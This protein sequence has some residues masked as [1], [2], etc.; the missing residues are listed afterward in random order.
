MLDAFEKILDIK[1]ENP[2]LFSVSL[3]KAKAEARKKAKKEYG[4]AVPTFGMYFV[5]KGMKSAKEELKV[6]EN[7][8]AY[9]EAQKPKVAELQD[10]RKKKDEVFAKMRLETLDGFLDTKEV[11]KEVKAMAH[12]KLQDLM[13]AGVKDAK[14]GRT[15]GMENVLT[16]ISQ[17]EKAEGELQGTDYFEGG[18]EAS[19]TEQDKDLGYK[20]SA[21]RIRASVQISI[22]RSVAKQI[23]VEIDKIS[24]NKPDALAEA[25]KKLLERTATK[26]VG[27]MPKEEIGA[28][29]GTVIADRKYVYRNDPVKILNLNLALAKLRFE[30]KKLTK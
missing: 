11:A 6:V 2:D 30:A 10:L 16:Y 24:R 9:L 8:I 14:V 26:G 12:Q 18:I 20:S 27:N 1:T 22:E 5:S 7:N 25:L 19:A 29:V 28:F 4:V 15:G 3:T 13:E 23:G 21:D 17:L